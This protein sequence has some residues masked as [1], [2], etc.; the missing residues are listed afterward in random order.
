P[1]DV[2]RLGDLAALDRAQLGVLAAQLRERFVDGRV[3]D[4]QLAPLDRQR[5]VIDRRDLTADLDDRG[6]RE[7]LALLDRR[8]FLDA[9]LGDRGEVVLLVRTEERLA[10]ELV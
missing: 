3:G 6:E 5:G 1:D 8:G 4:V 9:R 7:R 2:A 10:N